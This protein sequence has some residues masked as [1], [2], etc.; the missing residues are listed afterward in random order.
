MKTILFALLTSMLLLCGCAMQPVIPPTP[1]PINKDFTITAT[2]THD[3][4]NFAACS[5]T[6]TKGCITGFSWGYLTGSTQTVLHTTTTAACTGST[7]PMSCKDVM[8]SQLPIAPN[9]LPFFQVA[10]Y[11]DNT[12]ATGSIAANQFSLTL[13]AAA[14]TGFS[15]T[16]Q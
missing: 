5:T 2:W 13:N 3:F 12:G 10:N 7:Q 4:T 14:S 9:G 1:A 11:I 8:N 6:V 15:V 16:A